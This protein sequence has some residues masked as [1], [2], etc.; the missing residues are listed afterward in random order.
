MT[1]ANRDRIAMSQ[2]PFTPSKRQQAQDKTDGPGAI[3]HVNDDGPLRLV[4]TRRTLTLRCWRL[5]VIRFFSS[6][7]PVGIFTSVVVS[8]RL[9]ARQNA[10]QISY[11]CCCTARTTM[12]L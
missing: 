4:P 10:R 5:A 9:H 12:T 1:V 7:M 2:A 8:R 11:A 6:P 3:R